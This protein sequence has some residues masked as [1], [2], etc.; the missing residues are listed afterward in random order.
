MTATEIL[1]SYDNLS[2][3]KEGYKITKGRD[4]YLDWVAKWKAEYKRLSEDIR[5][6]KV[7]RKESGPCYD[8]DATWVKDVLRSHAYYML[9]TR[10]DAKYWSMDQRKLDIAC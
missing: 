1:N 9:V 10:S 5:K 3:L 4:E 6:L 2:A 8:S 7:M